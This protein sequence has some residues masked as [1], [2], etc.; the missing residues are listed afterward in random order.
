MTIVLCCVGCAG[1][2]R[3]TVE[4]NRTA[5][6]QTAADSLRSEV[7]LVWTEAVPQS[8]VRLAIPADSLMLLPPQATY[9]RKNGRASVSVARKGDTVTVYASCDSL[10]ALVVY[11]ERRADHYRKAFEAADARYEEEV[12]RRSNPIRTYFYGLGTGA[13]LG[14]LTMIFIQK[15]K[16]DGK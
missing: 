8:E 9:S 4:T 10:Q 2:R 15:R 7:R 3:T 13:V 6:V 16:K 12:K 14:V 5:A 1:T 11:Y